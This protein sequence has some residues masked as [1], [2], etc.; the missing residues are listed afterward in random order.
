MLLATTACSGAASGAADS[1]TTSTSRPTTT[2]STTLSTTVST[3]TTTTAPTTTTTTPVV[4]FAPGEGADLA[5]F[6]AV[7]DEALTGTSYAGTAY[8]DPELFVDTG[9]LFC[10]LLDRGLTV[11]DVLTAY[12]TVLAGETEGGEIHPDDL[13]L[14]GAVLG[15][16]VE[17]LCPQ[18][19]AALADEG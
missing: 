10:S 2:S 4:T 11:D 13:A 9:R 14:G 19:S 5:R 15:A 7:V 12:V 16:A 6:V 8:T 1:T 18:H 3:T 17:I